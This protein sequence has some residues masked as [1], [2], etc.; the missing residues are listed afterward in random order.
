MT[1]QPPTEQLQAT[2][3]ETAS[4]DQLANFINGEFVPPASGRYTDVIDPSTGDVYATAPLSGPDDVDRAFSA[5]ADAFASTWR[6][7]TPKDR[8]EALL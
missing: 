6:K 2:A 5:A 4:S 1:P 8:M 3:D 7:T